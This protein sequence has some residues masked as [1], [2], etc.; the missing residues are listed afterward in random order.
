MP[1]TETYTLNMG[2]QHPSTHGVL[3]VVLELDGERVVKAIPQMGYLHRG[4]EKLAESRT[5]T[6]F[7]PYT[8]RLDYVSSMGNNLGYCQTIE[9]L[10]AISVP[11]RAEYLRVIMTELNRIASHLI[12]M[13][14]VAIDLGATTGMMFGFRD[15]E[16]ILDLFDM[17]CGARLTYSY[18]RFG[19]V[20][21]D[22]PAEF[23]EATR[24][25]LADFPAMLTEHH[26]LLSGNEILHHRLK[27][28]GIISGQRAVETGLTGPTL[29]AS[30]VDYDIRKIEPYG[31]YDRFSFCVPL[32]TVGDNWDRYMVR[33]EEMQQSADIIAQALD[34]LPP[35]PVMTKI[36]KVLKPL[37][38][39]VYHR[40]ENP[41]G[42]LGYYVVSDGSTKPYRIHV[43]RPSFIN[44]QALNEICQGSLI[45]DVVAILATL[46][47]LMGEVDC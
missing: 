42:E 39:D 29:R 43:R 2:P 26:T 6:Q 44:L 21:E 27:G 19:G 37:P 7:I 46:D 36:P 41:R 40:I 9:K 28:S 31:I 34:Q 10:M 8:D 13:S 38:G 11:E 1:K 23:I 14:S 33:M 47:P 4:I 3:Q 30:G 18:I 5:Y 20:R 35:G 25:F 22:V 12:F 24:Q 15:R 17:A 16:R 45:A 32:G